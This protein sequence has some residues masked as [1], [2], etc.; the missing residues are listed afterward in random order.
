M[1]NKPKFIIKAIPVK[2]F[3]RIRGGKMERVNPF[4]REGDKRLEQFSSKP[5]KVIVEKEK[6]S[7]P[8]QPELEPKSN[9]IETAESWS[10]AEKFIQQNVDSVRMRKPNE[11]NVE[12]HDDAFENAHKEI[13]SVSGYL[14]GDTALLANDILNLSKSIFNQ[15][16]NEFKNIDPKTL[17]SFM[18][19]IVDKL[20]H[21]EIESNREQF[22]DHGIR[23]ISK[24][25]LTQNS[26]L[27]AL[28]KDSKVSGRERLLSIF[29]Q[30]NH[31]MGYANNDV[32]EFKKKHQDVSTN[33][34]KD[35]KHLWN[36]D[37]IFSSEEFDKAVD[38]ISTHDSSELVN[39]E[40]NLDPLSV[41]TR[42]AD[43]L[44]LFQEDKLPS[45]FQ[46]VNGGKDIL[47]KLGEAAK[48]KDQAEFNKI[49]TELW[50][51]IDEAP[52]LGKNLKRDLK[53]AT[54]RLN[55]F[56]PKF[57]LGTLAG[58]ITN[59]GRGED[60]LL[61]V[62]VHHNDFDS[63]L[64]KYFEMGQTNLKKFLKD[65]GIQDYNQKKYS[66]GDYKGKPIL[67]ISVE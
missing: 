55:F 56:T 30:V 31:D 23:H 16:K 34:I 14:A 46:Y 4:E 50:S 35:Q 38:L 58:E 36:V 41:S 59:I 24:N 11:I 45:M 5:S 21:Q 54:N 63:F 18:K 27:D 60:S 26:I 2:G 64:Q 22:T 40:G 12:K 42:L 9:R 51:K 20:I 47:V 57:A 48:N 62:N 8:E 65:Y 29:I 44:C 10:E 49:R 67:E 52:N 17:N 66:I 7:E 1:K 39:K 6:K 43:N 32:K 19:D 61:K 13:R 25:I 15:H 37:K 33:I 53:A 3:T 28:S